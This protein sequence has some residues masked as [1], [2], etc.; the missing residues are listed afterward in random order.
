MYFLYTKEN[1]HMIRCASN[2]V[3]SFSLELSPWES[4]SVVARG[5]YL[6]IDLDEENAT[7]GYARIVTLI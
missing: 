7:P 5:G 6:L 1:M 2:N 3:K 4:G